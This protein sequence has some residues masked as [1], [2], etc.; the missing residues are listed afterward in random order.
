MGKLKKKIAAITLNRLAVHNITD[1]SAVLQ[2]KR[3]DQNAKLEIIK[4]KEARGENRTRVLPV[5]S[6]CHL[7]PI[8]ES[9]IHS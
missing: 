4:F 1:R 3:R 7:L 6:E 5:E 8:L 9:Y 2:P